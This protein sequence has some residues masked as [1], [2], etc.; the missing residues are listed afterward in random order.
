MVVN[1]CVGVSNF[2]M[3]CHPSPQKWPMGPAVGGQNAVVEHHPYL[4]SG[5]LGPV[6]GR[7]QEMVKT[8]ARVLCA[9]AAQHERALMRVIRASPLFLVGALQ[10]QPAAPA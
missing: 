6:I 9:S 4:G 8:D 5:Q 10:P 1:V 2:V 7:F 3:E